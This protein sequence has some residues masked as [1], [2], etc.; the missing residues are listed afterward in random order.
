MCPLF[1]INFYFSPNDSPSKTIK[2]CF[3]FHL[4]DSFRSRDIHFFLYLSSPLFLPASHSFRGGSKISLKVY[5][6]INCLNK[7]LRTHFVRYLEKEKRYDI[8]TFFI[9][10][11]LN[12][13]H[14]YRK[15]MQKICTKGQSQT[16]F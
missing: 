6:V 1:F 2:K 10:R 15:I 16:H 7:N 14:F 13:E 5:D 11:V 4:K 12:K 8:E 9:D 3:L